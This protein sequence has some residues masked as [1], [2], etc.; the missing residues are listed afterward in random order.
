LKGRH[1]IANTLAACVLAGVGG[2]PIQVLRQGAITFS[3]V[4]HRQRLVL[5]RSGVRW[6][7]D[8]SATTPE[9]TVVALRAF[10]NDPIV[11]LAG[12]RDKHLPWEDMTALIWTRARHLILFGEAAGLIEDAM[13]NSQISVSNSCRI[14]HGGTLEG[15]VEIAAQV[16]RP[17]DVVLLS[18]GG[19]SFDAYNNFSE[20]G[21]HFQQ[22]VRALE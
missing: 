5:E 1:N 2:A 11:L 13:Y 21:K 19:T 7:D 4:E 17:G 14:H 15:A 3:G 6:Y 20:R 9:R 16:A 22:L 12:G 8:S 18:P 10:P